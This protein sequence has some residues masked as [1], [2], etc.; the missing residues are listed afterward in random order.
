LQRHQI[1]QIR[2]FFHRRQAVV[3]G[4]HVLFFELTTV[5][6][7]LYK[8]RL[9]V[10]AK[11]WTV[12]ITRLFYAAATTE[13][14]QTISAA[15]ESLLKGKEQYSWPPCMYWFRSIAL[16]G[17]TNFFLLLQNNLTK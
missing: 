1:F 17:E 11:S 10:V 9:E 8:V 4:R 3:N 7:A 12:F 5:S 6:P 13:A 2:L 14:K 15:T 16:H